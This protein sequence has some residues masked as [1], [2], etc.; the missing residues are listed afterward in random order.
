MTPNQP[1]P[2]DKWL[3]EFKTIWTANNLEWEP[4]FDNPKS[5]G[6]YY[7]EDFSPQDAFDEEMDAWRQNL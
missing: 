7:D 5:W 3:A 6:E 2:F 4:S 1:Q